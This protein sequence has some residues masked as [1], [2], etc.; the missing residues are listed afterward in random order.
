MGFL[1]DNAGRRWDELPAPLR[2]LLLA[3]RGFTAEDWEVIRATP[4]HRTPEGAT[5]LIPDDIRHRADIDAERADA[6]AARLM[7]TIQEQLEFAVPSGSL[8]GRATLLGNAPPGSF[9]GELLRSGIMFKSFALSLAF[10]WLRRLFLAPVNGSRAA[11]IAAFFAVTTV[12]GAASLQLKEIAKGRDPRDM[13]TR[14]FAG[15][16][17][18]QGGGLGIFGD[19]LS[20]STNRFGG[21]VIGT[22]VGPAVETGADTLGFLTQTV[23]ALAEGRDPHVGRRIVQGL[24]FNT[25]LAN[26]WWMGLATQRLGFD[27]LQKALDPEAERAWRR[28]ERRRVKEFGNP[29][30]FPPGGPLRAPDLARAFGGESS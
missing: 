16:A 18:L 27:S 8:R 10:G 17:M 11:N 15:A 24:R 29:A 20:S 2:E 6:L 23:D 12:A 13:T 1:A 14:E 30:F 4:L 19:F 22:L 25:P 28:A 21:G 26:L 5:F 9:P 7:G 3:A